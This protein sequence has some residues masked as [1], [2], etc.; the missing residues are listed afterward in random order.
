MIRPDREEARDKVSKL[1]SELEEHQ[2]RLRELNSACRM[3]KAQ[4]SNGKSPDSVGIVTVEQG[5][6]RLEVLLKASPETDL[7]APKVNLL[8]QCLRLPYMASLD[9]THAGAKAQNHAPKA[10]LRRAASFLAAQDSKS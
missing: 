4:C 10:S 6:R 3:G 8:L 2:L 7:P 1:R 5:L 9:I